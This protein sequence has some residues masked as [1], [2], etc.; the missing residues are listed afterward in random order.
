L[1]VTDARYRVVLA[2]GAALPLRIA[3]PIAQLILGLTMLPGWAARRVRS[4][5]SGV[6]VGRVAVGRL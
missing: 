1:R 4:R 5:F 3:G 6:G 2:L